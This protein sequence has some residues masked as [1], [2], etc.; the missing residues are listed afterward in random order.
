MADATF[1]LE[2]QHAEAVAA[3]FQALVAAQFGQPPSRVPTSSPPV[4]EPRRGDPIALLTLLLTILPTLVA[5]DDLVK[6]YAVGGSA[7][8]S[9][10]R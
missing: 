10:C 4:G 3:E 1:H 2:G 6:R 7:P 5:V 9:A 8:R